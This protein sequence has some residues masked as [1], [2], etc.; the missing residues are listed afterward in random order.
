M[1]DIILLLKCYKHSI[2][3]NISQQNPIRKSNLKSVLIR[4]FRNIT[5]Q[6]SIQKSNLKSVLIRNHRNITRKNSI[7][8]LN[9]NSVMKKNSKQKSNLNLKNINKI[10]EN[11]SHQIL[12]NI[13]KKNDLSNELQRN[14]KKTIK[15]EHIIKSINKPINKSN[16]RSINKNHKKIKVDELTNLN[17]KIYILCH[18]EKILEQSMCIYSIYKWAHPILMKYQDA[19]FENAFWAQMLEIES[20]WINYDMVGILSNKANS[21]LNLECINRFSLKN[22]NYDFYHFKPCNSNITILKKNIPHP[23]FNIIWKTIL[24][25]LNLNDCKEYYCNYWIC[26]PILMKNFIN[27]YLNIALPI[28]KKHPLIMSNAEYKYASLTSNELIKLCDVPYYPMLPFILERLNPCY[29]IN[30]T[31]INNNIR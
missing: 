23:N 31:Q 17:I 22:N 12:I 28:V 16:N 8:K 10:K 7:R 30:F 1:N 25:E 13:N 3:K 26:K 4:N 18:N 6:N 2:K 15:S 14:L 20:E 11:R 21:K 9:L 5:K 24:E 27:W 19:S 29:F